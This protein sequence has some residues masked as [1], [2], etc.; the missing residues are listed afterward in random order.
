M[1]ALEP[2]LAHID[3]EREQALAR[4]LELLRIPSV[5]T[6]PAHDGDTRRAAAWLERRLQAIGLD[7]RIAP[8]AGQPMVVAHDPGPGGEVPHV[9]YYGHY[10]VQPA[11]PI[12][13][14]DSPPFEPTLVEGPHG[15]RIVARGAVDDK[16]QTMSFIEALGAW[17]AVHG[18]LP[19]RVTVLLEGEEE[20]GSPSLPAFLAAHREELRADVGIV[21]DTASWD[22][23]TPAIT[24]ALRGQ[25]YTEITLDGPN[26][27]LHSGMYG[28]PALNPIN[29]L[30]RILG[31]LHDAS[32]K[33]TI[34]GFY[35]G[36]GEPEPAQK[37]AWAALGFDAAAFL[38][39]VGLQVPAGEKDRSALEQLWSRPTADLCGIHGGYTGPG[40][41]TVIAARASAKLSFRLVPGQ[42]PERILDGL[43]RFLE[44]RRP[45]DARITLTRHSASPGIR[46]PG[47]S[48]YLRAVRRGLA[49]VYGREPVL[50]GCG[51]SIPIVGLFQKTLGFDSLLVG[52]GLEDD[53]IHAP[54]EKFELRC[55]ENGVRAHAA[56]L[57]ELAAPLA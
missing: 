39:A 27:D 35:D 41:K 55:F 42:D 12:E 30:V 11:D 54:N 49:R 13:L 28:G 51:A 10:D 15:T 6:D 32:G 19:F 31:E 8:T 3:A 52:F 17:R 57:S 50:I 45:P 14:W 34:P 1:T 43:A 7:A 26:R 46:I 38:G 23:D 24:T 5:G 29:A 33:V 56:I 16:G 2:V 44:E 22:I 21:S 48:P 18:R 25:V 9:L 20:S 4:L 47:D 36:V 40:A 53:R 37:A